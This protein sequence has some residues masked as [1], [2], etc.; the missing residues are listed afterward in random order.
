MR[1]I[2]LLGVLWVA[3]PVVAQPDDELAKQVT[4]RRTDYGVPHIV[5]ATE[6][7]A[8]CWPGLPECRRSCR[9]NQA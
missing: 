2:A 6:K 5:A 7:A 4:N 1:V 3:F 9:M 8:D